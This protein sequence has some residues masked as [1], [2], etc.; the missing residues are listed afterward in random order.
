MSALS[1]LAVRRVLDGGIPPTLC[2]VSADGIP[3]VN[4]LSHVEYVDG[5]HVA[6]TFQFFNHSREN[7]LATGRA[8]LMVEDPCTGASLALQLRY[9]RTET[10]GPVFERLRAKL[11]GI[12]AHTGMEDVFRLRGADIYEV[13]GIQAMHGG[14]SLPT[15]QP[16]CDL[17]AGARAVS[18]RL[19]ECDELSLLPQIAMDGLRRELAVNHAILWLLDEQRQTLYALASMGYAQQ[20]VGA[21]VPLA[22]AGL[23]GV[24]AREGV[25]LRIGHMARM[26][27]YG[28]TLHQMASDLRP[29]EG[30]PI[31]LPGLAT[32]CS[33]LAVPL[34]ARGR[35]VGA[36]LVEAE[37]D[38]FF[39]Y[40]DED[41]LAVLCAQLAQALVA[42]QGAELDAGTPPPD[43]ARAG[44]GAHHGA[45][46]S[47]RYFPRDG[48]VF[49]DGQYLIKGVAGAILWKL[50]CD[51]LRHGRWGFST[52]ELR[53]AGSSLGLPDVQ[54]NLGVRLLLLQRR[55]AD[56]GGPLQI[57]KLRRG[58][59]E[60]VSGRALTLESAGES[61]P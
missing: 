58:C 20:G 12:A 36:L 43:E 49:V 42:L 22:E 37:S 35:T 21:E 52:R 30:Q 13:R 11:A 27:R 45:P 18:T 60:L 9:L 7:I 33:Q 24:A 25:A 55:L 48:T 32:P 23:A 53:L 6:L 51:A 29:I 34:R 46:L 44:P 19:A 1:L 40:D 2:S 38:Q 31:A 5:G 3:H 17:A 54:D 14:A 57:R 28:R 16:R 15:L 59:Y 26:Y 8:S 61:A 50:A 10:E 39:G 4:L 56:W 41:A 47:L